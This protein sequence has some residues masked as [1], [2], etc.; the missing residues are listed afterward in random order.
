MI[1]WM[2]V[3]IADN[4][5]CVIDGEGT[6]C[7]NPYFPVSKHR[8]YILRRSGCYNKGVV[9]YQTQECMS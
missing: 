9:T 8:Y 1:S 6:Y 5:W 2:I 4:E 7:E 3:V